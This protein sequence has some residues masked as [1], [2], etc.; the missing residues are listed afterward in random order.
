MRPS[1]VGRPTKQH[2]RPFGTCPP[3]IATRPL[4]HDQA[5]VAL[6]TYCGGMGFWFDPTRGTTI[7]TGV[8]ALVDQGGGGKDVAQ[9][10]GLAQPALVLNVVNLRPILRFISANSQVL[11]RAATNLW[12]TGAYAIMSVQKG[13]T[14]NQTWVA[15][16]SAA[17][18]TGLSTN[19]SNSAIIHFGVAAFVDGAISAGF[20]VWSANRG[21]AAKPT[22]RSAGALLTLTG[23][24]TTLADA[25][26]G[27]V[28]TLGARNDT[29]ALN[30]FYDGDL[31][32]TFGFLGA[33]PAIIER[34]L[35]CW[36]GA[37]YALP[38][39]WWS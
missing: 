24:A 31:A 19:G 15:D 29:G 36:L 39:T 38:V 28:L 18:G 9:A 32:E 23:A 37:R 4:I 20:E 21:A 27:G 25:G 8:S 13:N 30:A 16:T 2:G 3:T 33:A 17:G 12:G 35:Q 7:A 11:S 34:Q 1:Y 6:S 26:A 5:P 22:L 10:T 14:V